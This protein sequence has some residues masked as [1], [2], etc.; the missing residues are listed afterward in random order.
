MKKKSILLLFIMIFLVAFFSWNKSQTKETTVALEKTAELPPDS[1]Q[2]QLKEAPPV[3]S[4]ASTKNEKFEKLFK[5]VPPAASSHEEGEWAQEITYEDDKYIGSR[6]VLGGR[7]VDN[8]FF[9]WKKS[10]DNEAIE[11]IAGEL[12]LIKDI[13]GPFPQKEQN[14]QLAQELTKGKA[15]IIA[16]QEFWK[17]DS[18]SVLSPHLRIQVQYQS[19]IKSGHEYWIVDL[20][21]GQIV[22]RIE[23]DRY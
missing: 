14:A 18:N 12:P 22:R 5:L 16:L 4:P 1:P 11:H 15:E 8:Y 23:A 9:K 17:I 6:L 2:T 20:E 19:N 10:P 21:S 3:R 13:Q 7:P